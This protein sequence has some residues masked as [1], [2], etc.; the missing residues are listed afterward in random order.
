VFIIEGFVVAQVPRNVTFTDPVRDLLVEAL[1]VAIEPHSAIY[2]SA[3]ITTGKRHLEL[4]RELGRQL[5]PEDRHRHFAEV[6]QPNTEHASAVT[7]ALRSATR[8]VVI[9]PAAF[10]PMVGWSQEDWLAL[11]SAVIARYAS[12]VV[13]VDDWQFSNGCVEEY[14]LAAKLSLPTF[15]ENGGVINVLAAISMIEE[16][17]AA[18]ASIESAAEVID[19]KLAILK[20]LAR[21]DARS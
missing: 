2:C 9:D 17:V 19:R 8:D 18:L 3:P 13:F 15:D 1:G 14:V 12:K 7:K 10:P 6:I 4:I 16:A 20:S 11:W 21:D 5:V